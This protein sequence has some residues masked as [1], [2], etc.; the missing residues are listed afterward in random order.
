MFWKRVTKAG[1]IA[2]MLTGFT[3]SSFWL[4]F[5][6]FKEA[7]ALGLCKATFGTNSLIGGKVAFVDA[8]IVALPLSALAL[9]IVSLMTKPTSKDHLKKC[10]ED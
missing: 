7:K 6:H 5:V 10:F 9:V 4:L 2:S 1:A 3:V 8:L